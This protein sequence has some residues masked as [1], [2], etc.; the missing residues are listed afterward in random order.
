MPLVLLEIVVQVKH[1]TPF[2]YY[3]CAAMRYT[4]GV[5]A[6]T[7]LIF[8]LAYQRVLNDVL[9]GFATDENVSRV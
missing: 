5:E 1:W 2:R 6:M 3:A 7:T 4:H 9:M 8:L